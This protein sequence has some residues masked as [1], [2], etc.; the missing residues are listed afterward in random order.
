MANTRRVPVFLLILNID[1][2]PKYFWDFSKLCLAFSFCT[3]FFLNAGQGFHHWATS[4]GVASIG[5][6]GG[7]AWWA[8]QNTIHK[9]PPGFSSLLGAR[10]KGFCEL[11]GSLLGTDPLASWASGADSEIFPLQ[12]TSLS[13]QSKW[14]RAGRISHTTFCTTGKGDQ[15]T[16]PAAPCT[17]AFQHL[18]RIYT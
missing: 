5:V 15:H 2:S 6:S 16:V 17:T 18:D 10:N 9:S 11:W 14:T 4:P 3:I 7:R 13:R 8:S 1:L 12:V